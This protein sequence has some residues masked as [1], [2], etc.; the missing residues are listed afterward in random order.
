M[1][2][3]KRGIDETKVK[4]Q[5]LLS[6]DIA[7][8]L[9]IWWANIPKKETVESQL[10]GPLDL[11]LTAEYEGILVGFVLAR[12]MHANIPI[13]GA[14]CILYIAINPDYQGCGIS[15]MLIDRLKHD[16]QAKGI[17]V[18]CS[19]VSPEVNN[20]LVQYVE[21]VGFSPSNVFAYQSPI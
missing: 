4:I 19:F 10:G 1:N 15:A 6:K 8:K 11:S 5:P 14:G 18:L 2:S 17:E 13:T 12:V 21:K 7:S 20:D 16:C 9:S 3:A